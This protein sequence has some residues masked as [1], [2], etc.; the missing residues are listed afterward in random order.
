MVRIDRV[1]T[2]TGDDG[3]TA[4]GD[5]RRLA[6][7]HPLII[8]LGEIDEANCVLGLVAQHQPPAAVTSEL[9]RVQN[10]L[11]DLGADC[12]LPAASPGAEH[13]PRIGDRH[14]ARLDAALESA[15]AGL[16]PLT[17]FILPGGSLAAAWLH[18]AR[19]VVRRAE[20]SLV[21]AR[22]HNDPP[23]NEACVRYLNR[24]SDLCFVWARLANNGHDP[25]WQPGKP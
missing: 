22:Q 24:L 9:P 2:R 5:G 8:A 1:T 18:L 7:N 14:L 17:S 3:T 6:K 12:C 4:L 10:E 15:N 23:V 25:L 20:R 11:F 13:C 21:T 16:L 19:T